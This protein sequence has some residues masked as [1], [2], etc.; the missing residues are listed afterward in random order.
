MSNIDCLLVAYA[1]VQP[2]IET[3]RKYSDKKLHHSKPVFNAAIAYLCTFLNRRH[4]SFD[5]VCSFED[6][7]DILF[8]KLQENVLVVGISTTFCHNIKSIC[9]MVQFVRKANPKAK[10]IIG[11]SYSVTCLNQFSHNQ[12][13]LLLRKIGAD[14]YIN[15]YKGETELAL[16]VEAIKK[17]KQ[18]SDIP[19]ILYKIDDDIFYNPKADISCPLEE[20][21]VDWSLFK[22]NITNIVPVRTS[23][24]CMY[25]CA[26]CSFHVKAGKYSNI[27]VDAVERELNSL[28]DS[29]CVKMV[30]FIDDS[31]NIPNERY[32]DILCMMIRN[33]YPFKWHSYIRC[34]NLDEETVSL[35]KSSG[36]QGV[37]IGFE[38]GSQI[39]LD[40]MNKRLTLE[41]YRHGHALLKKYDIVSIGMFII[42]FPGET[43]ETVQETIDF[44]NEINPTFYH[45]H[46]WICDTTTPI[47]ETKR[48]IWIKIFSEWMET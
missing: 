15:S 37:I 34:Q 8:Q 3:L 7:K 29:N 31:F 26:Y 36:C 14:I 45:A 35:M 20:N 13:N 21:T 40:R 9:E 24:S 18:L 28:K 27:S 39:M 16:V 33:K 30:N 5:Y 38:S 25:R 48:T 32:K 17:N 46:A 22:D 10:I 42:G 44:I 41:D 47:L 11:G 1:G 6:E 12:L 19:N 43:S 4:L 23:I 2:N